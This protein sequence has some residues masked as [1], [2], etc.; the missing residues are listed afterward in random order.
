MYSGLAGQLILYITDMVKGKS[1]LA[2]LEFKEV[3][4]TF[5]GDC[6]CFLCL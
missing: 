6:G 2:E 1:V 4:L 3:A 5:I